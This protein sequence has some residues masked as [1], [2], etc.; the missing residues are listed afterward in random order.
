LDEV[1]LTLCTTSGTWPVAG[2]NVPLKNELD[3]DLLL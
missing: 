1:A 2:G 3:A